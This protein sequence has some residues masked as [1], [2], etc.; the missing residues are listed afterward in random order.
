MPSR[1]LLSDDDA[2]LL[3]SLAEQFAHEG[4]HDVVP[5]LG[6]DAAMAAV[7]GLPFVLAIIGQPGEH[8]SA[9]AGRLRDA[10][11]ACPI[12]LLTDDAEAESAGFETLAKP[13]RFAALLA[14]VHAL[15]TH[16]AADGDVAVRI[17]P[18]TFHPSAKLLQAEGRRVRLTEKET[19][20]LKFLHASAGT[21]PRETLLHEV[22]GYGPAVATHTL[23]THIYRL[24]KKI[25]EDPGRAQILLTEG[26]GY[27][28]CA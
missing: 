14:K 1:I 12:L 11:L 23:E 10:G 4:Q 5:A 19:N 21:V 22:W 6:A 3:A 7:P 15:T 25:E 18:Y 13:F 8:G 17:G 2:V 16:H 20:I 28:L 27:R 9:L 24:R 26:G